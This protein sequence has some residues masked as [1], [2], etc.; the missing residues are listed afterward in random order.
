M[1]RAFTAALVVVPFCAFPASAS[2]PVQHS[3]VAKPVVRVGPET[4]SP[5]TVFFVRWSDEA[6]AVAVGA[7]HSFD[8]RKLVQAGEVRFELGRSRRSVAVS[9]RLLVPPGRPFSAPGASLLD[10]YVI[11][12]LDFAPEHVRLLDLAS[13]LPESGSR[14]RVLGVPATLPHDEDDVFGTVED[15][16]EARIEVEL[17]VPL[18][19]RGWGG[20]PVLDDESGRVVGM[21]QGAVPMRR[22]LALAV[23][24]IASVVEALRRPLDSGRGLPFREASARAHPETARLALAEPAGPG[25]APSPAAAPPPEAAPTGP[26]ARGGREAGAQGPRQERPRSVAEDLSAAGDLREAVD[27]LFMEITYPPDGSIVG[28][29]NGGFVA[30]RARTHR[31]F[32][33]VFVIDT[34]ASTNTPSGADVNGN[35][36][37]GDGRIGP[38]WNTDPGDSILAA[39]VAAARLFVR[40]LDPRSTR[41][42]LLTF[43]GS[44]AAGGL[45]GEAE[46]PAITHVPLT[47]E[48]QEIEHQLDRIL[49]NRGL[50]GTHMAAGV[51][52]ATTELLGF[53]GGLSEPNRLSR[54]F[55]LFLTDGVPE[56]PYESNPSANVRAVL[57]AADRARRV[58]IVFHT[59][60]IGK[61][62]LDGPI[63]I[64]ELAKRTNGTF[65]PV[66]HPADLSD[67]VAQIELASIEKLELHNTTS[68]TSAELV[69]LRPDGSWNGLVPLVPG[70]NEIRAVA[71]TSAGQEIAGRVAIEYVPGAADPTL[72]PELLPQRTALLER[73]LLDLKRGR[74]ATEREAAEQA[75]K[76][77][78]VEIEKEREAAERKAAQQR[79]ELEIEPAPE[80]PE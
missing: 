14:V 68:S 3:A 50:G 34:S 62:A 30:G 33:V 58:G 57:Q 39:E 61:K 63:A 19:L 9:S 54:K 64:V 16:T 1:R 38:F 43:A 2:N 48:Y 67:V 44:Q 45:F 65:T 5:G 12:S 20:A 60:G 71:R 4:L 66:S 25:A 10:D 51:D 47:R 35:G 36:I 80:S 15:V 22:G 37:T 26:H 24:P 52:Q 40:R 76:E 79:K 75:R 41:V 28:D 31:E 78:L 23:S 56:L 73:R 55:V 18:D 74:V 46:P 72:P 8:V 53:R 42:A 17:D 21:L 6:G 59:F 69:N 7:A 13:E 32:D 29:P 11:F 70:R 77:L 49:E 27:E